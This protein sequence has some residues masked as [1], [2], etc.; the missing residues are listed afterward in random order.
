MIRQIACAAAFALS[1][2]AAWAESV[3]VTDGDWTARFDEPTNRYGHAIMGNLPEWGRVCLIGPGAEACVRL[4]QTSVFEDIAPRLADVDGD[5][6]PEAVVVESAFSAGAALVVYRLDNGALTRIATPHIGTR[7]RW[8]APAAIA[9]LDGDG[10]VELAYID[11]PH[12]AKRLRVWRYVDGALV[13][14]ADQGGLTNHRIGEPF[15]TGGLRDCGEGPESITAS[16]TWREL[17]A[18]R[19]VNGRQEARALG[20][21]SH[22]AAENAVN[23][24]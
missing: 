17:V 15:I 10:A 24:Q 18:T 4:P 7:N 22:A 13:H 3:A 20:R 9:D 2:A 5:G 14:V 12:L 8:L 11:R 21:F 23:C 1:A 6:T 16:A 19:L